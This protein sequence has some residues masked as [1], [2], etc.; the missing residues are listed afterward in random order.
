M[1][2]YTLRKRGD[3]HRP[4]L[5]PIPTAKHAEDAAC[6]DAAWRRLTNYQKGRL[7]MLARKAS[8]KCGISSHEETEWRREQSILACGCRISEA[9]QAHW[10]DLKS[11]FQDLAGEVEK[12]FQTQMREGDNKRRVAMWKLTQALNAKGLQTTYAAA[13]CRAQFKCALEDASAKQLWCLF[14]T[15]TNRKKSAASS[16]RPAGKTS[17]PMTNDP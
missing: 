11:R 15:V 2:H 7:S 3:G 10:A 14:Y 12:A 8:V 5:Q 16:Q 4:T 9:T 17:S 1:K 6:P 13:I